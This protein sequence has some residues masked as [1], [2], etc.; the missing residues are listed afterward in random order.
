MSLSESTEVKLKLQTIV[1]AVFTIAVSIAAGTFAL[2]SASRSDHIDALEAKI[3]SAEVAQ[4]P[5]PTIETPTG[6]LDPELRTL[7]VRIDDLEKEREALV[8]ELVTKSTD[9]LDPGSELAGLISQVN[10]DSSRLRMAGAEGLFLLNDP[11]AV[12]TLVGYLNAHRKEAINVRHMFE[13]YDMLWETDPQA[14]IVVGLNNFVSSE[15]ADAERAYEELYRHIWSNR[16]SASSLSRIETIA[17]TSE[18]SLI[19][20]RAKLLLQR[21]AEREAFDESREAERMISEQRHNER[22]EAIEGMVQQRTVREIL[23]GIEEK[24]GIEPHETDQ[25]KG[26]GDP[27]P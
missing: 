14:A 11:R 12:P 1:V 18:N 27:K 19:R 13:W 23:L 17:L 20:T 7:R 9:T 2:T 24:L 6:R 21:L 3:A 26:S 16:P 22:M 5:L 4:L 8:E 10:S 25:P 15:P